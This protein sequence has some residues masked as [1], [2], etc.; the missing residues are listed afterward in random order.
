MGETSYPHPLSGAAHRA[1]TPAAS[2]HVCG[3]LSGRLTPFGAAH[4]AV[5]IPLLDNN[6]Y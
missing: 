6:Q 4:H 1:S 3:A 5:L 2:P